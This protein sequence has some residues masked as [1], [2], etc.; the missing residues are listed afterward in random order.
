MADKMSDPRELFLHELV[1]VLYTEKM[2]GRQILPKLAKEASDQE[3]AKGFEEHADV[4]KRHI[5]NVEA[6]FKEMGEKPK[7][8]KCP[9]IEGLREEHD[10]FMKEEK[11]A[12]EIVDMFNT[13][14]A[15]RTEHYEIAAYTGLVTSARAL[16][17]TK[18]AD[19]LERN[20]RDEENMLE[21]VEK[22]AERLARAQPIT[23]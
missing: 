21:R 6:A 13:G 19:L 22:I 23:A 15:A 2:L 12:P 5:E 14:A 17:E 9:G 1:D 8:E 7:T 16:G 4:T 20:L 11:P 18:V 3:L 10:Q